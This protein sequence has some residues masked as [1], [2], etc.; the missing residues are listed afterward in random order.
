MALSGHDEQ[1]TH[2][3]KA[4]VLAC[5]IDN[6]AKAQDIGFTSIVLSAERATTIK[7]ILTVSRQKD[8]WDN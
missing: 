4:A 1:F 3:A 6:L 2:H 7:I 5:I 8:G